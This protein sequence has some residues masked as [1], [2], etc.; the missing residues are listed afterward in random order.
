MYECEAENQ[1]KVSKAFVIVDGKAPNV[2]ASLN[3]I[4]LPFRIDALERIDAQTCAIII[5][6]LIW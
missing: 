4:R 1:F 6:A 5:N 3:D 2:F